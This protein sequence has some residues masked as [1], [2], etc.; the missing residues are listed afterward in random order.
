[1]H[2]AYRHILAAHRR[3]PLSDAF[4]RRGYGSEKLAPYLCPPGLLGA[5]SA[6]TK[7]LNTMSGEDVL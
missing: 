4:G 3:C 2:G 5:G 6:S 7:A 1:M